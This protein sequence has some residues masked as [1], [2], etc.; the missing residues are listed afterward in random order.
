I[1]GGPERTGKRFAG[2]DAGWVA[3]GGQN[4]PAARDLVFGDNDIHGKR[5]ARS[6]QAG[7][8][9]R[10]SVLLFHRLRGGAI[11]GRAERD[12]RVPRWPT[13]SLSATSL[14]LCDCTKRRVH[15]R[16]K[17]LCMSAS[18]S[19]RSSSRRRPSISLR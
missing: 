15:G 4:A 17:T 6:V 2:L 5:A 18:S 1:L 9:T 16:L 3:S 10:V 12:V 11:N 7:L 19:G 13:V 8:G 14:S